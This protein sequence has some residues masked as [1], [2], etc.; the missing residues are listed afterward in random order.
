MQ[1]F[2]SPTL[3]TATS[4]ETSITLPESS[5]AGGNSSSAARLPKVSLNPIKA[6]S[7]LTLRGL[8]ISVLL[9]YFITQLTLAQN[10]ILAAVLSTSLGLILIATLTLTMFWSWYLRST[11]SIASLQALSSD[12]S[13]AASCVEAGASTVLTLSLTRFSLPPFFRLLAEIT[14]SDDFEPNANSIKA[15]SE[16]A[17]LSPSKA[18]NTTA[19]FNIIFPHR[20]EWR[21]E[22]VEFRLSDRF[23]LTQKS[24]L[25]S[26][27]R[28]D[29]TNRMKLAVDPANP[30]RESANFPIIA[31]RDREGD[32]LNQSNSRL[33]EP[34]DLKRYNPS[35]GLKKVVWKVF[36]RSG[37]LIS[38]HPESA[39][40]PEGECYIY[41]IAGPS[42]L[43]DQ[44]SRAAFDYCRTLEDAG[45]DLRLGC[46][47]SIKA[48]TATSS[49]DALELLRC[50]AWTTHST[51][52]PK[53][54][55]SQLTFLTRFRSSISQ[56]K[57]IDSPQLQP[58]ASKPALN[59]DSDAITHNLSTLIASFIASQPT[60]P[61]IQRLIIFLAPKDTR[62]ENQIINALIELSRLNISPVI[63]LA[64]DRSSALP[65]SQGKKLKA[66]TS[67]S[68]LRRWFWD[69]PLNISN[70][71]NQ[72]NCLNLMQIGAQNRWDIHLGGN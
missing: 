17:L 35:D 3:M 61:P 37:E 19:I 64:T 10:D 8:T 57:N 14:L 47:G 16:L 48:D 31:S 28:R 45:V 6:I 39:M 52:N 71:K 65:T 55:L 60:T 2:S 43:G 68:L 30:P 42:S 40:T 21:V 13:A 5:H 62:E 54:I 27:Y 51:Q 58:I 32:T 53:G 23:G 33:G 15:T 70:D 72:V 12:K 18:S 67:D 66:Q 24:W 46:A 4:P 1:V 9:Y 59:K 49:T 26:N 36:A 20:G 22:S 7:L 41:V 34:F 38:R 50:S 63:M 29:N 11:L 25:I 56:V 44:V 69:E